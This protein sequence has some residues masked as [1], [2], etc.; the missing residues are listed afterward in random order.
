MSSVVELLIVSLIYSIILMFA[1]VQV[2]KNF[3]NIRHLYINTQLQKL[4]K[5]DLYYL[6]VIELCLYI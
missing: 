1:Y 4:I 6:I 3:D 2:D 5:H